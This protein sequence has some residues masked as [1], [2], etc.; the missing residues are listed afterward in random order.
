MLDA[1]PYVK[2]SNKCESLESLAVKYNAYIHCI[3][4]H[5]FYEDALKSASNPQF[6]T[7]RSMS[8]PSHKLYLSD[9]KKHKVCGELWVI[10][11]GNKL[12]LS[13]ILGISIYFY[14]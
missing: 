11:K 10:R 2:D 12:L 9:G 7:T 1:L 3:Y 13:F 8:E 5:S 14:F 6:V 4:I